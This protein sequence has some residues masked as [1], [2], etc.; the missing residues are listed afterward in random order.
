M[1]VDPILE[2]VWRIK[3]AYAAR[4][5]YDLKAMAEDLRRSQEESRRAGR[6]IVSLPPKCVDTKERRAS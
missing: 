4:F 2:E 3:D 1:S 5:N 6:K